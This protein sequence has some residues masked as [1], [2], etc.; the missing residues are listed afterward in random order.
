METH[1][2]GGLRSGFSGAEEIMPGRAD[3]LVELRGFEPMA[4][5]RAGR[6]RAIAKSQANNFMAA[7]TRSSLRSAVSR[8]GRDVRSVDDQRYLRHD[9]V[10]ITNVQLG[11]DCREPGSR[12]C[13]RAHHNDQLVDARAAFLLKQFDDLR[14]LRPVPGRSP[15]PSRPI[16]SF[17]RALALRPGDPRYVKVRHDL[18]SV[19]TPARPSLATTGAS[20]LTSCAC[21]N[22]NASRNPR[23][24]PDPGNSHTTPALIEAGRHIAPRAQDPPTSMPSC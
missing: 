21:S 19:E 9:A 14:Q 24:E 22:R 16:R 2:G 7:S 10:G 15:V 13:G 18:N 12:F 17:G 6:S 23:F 3:F 20:A 4:I 11:D 5:A 1:F 8:P